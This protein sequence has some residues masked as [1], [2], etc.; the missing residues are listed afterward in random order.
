MLLTRGTADDF[1]SFIDDGFTVGQHVRIGGS[2]NDT[3]I[4]WSHKH[5]YF[6]G[7]KKKTIP[8]ASWVHQFVGDLAT[9]D[10][11]LNPNGEIKIEIPTKDENESKSG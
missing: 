9:K 10:E 7:F 11:T 6:K 3:L 1:G 4:D 5:K 8:C 2:G